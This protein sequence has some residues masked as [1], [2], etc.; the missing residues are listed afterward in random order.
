MSGGRRVGDET[1][2]VGISCYAL[3][4]SCSASTRYLRKQSSEAMKVVLCRSSA[5]SN[6][7]QEQT[8]YLRQEGINQGSWVLYREVCC[9]SG[10]DWEE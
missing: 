2:A 8:M 7:S 5:A 3:L 10:L 6:V 1:K 9:W 4:S